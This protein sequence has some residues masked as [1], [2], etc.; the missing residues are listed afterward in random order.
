MESDTVTWRA[1]GTAIEIAFETHT[2]AKVKIATLPPT[3]LACEEVFP[4]TLKL[5]Q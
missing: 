2:D 4:G 3:P 5:V 1:K